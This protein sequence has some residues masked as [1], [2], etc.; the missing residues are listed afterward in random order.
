MSTAVDARPRRPDRRSRTRW[1]LVPELVALG[2]LVVALAFFGDGSGGLRG[3]VARA[4]AVVVE[5]SSPTASHLHDE[6]GPA[7]AQQTFC[8][9]DV[10]GTDPPAAASLAEVRMVYGYY[11][12]ASGTHGLTYA[13]SN[14][15]DGPVV[16]DLKNRVASIAASGAGYDGRVRAMMP[17]QYEARCFGGLQNERVAAAVHDRYDAAL[18]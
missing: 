7:A 2:V 16:V 3:E 6:D 1:W 5:A 13:E 18:T 9:V 15:A 12:C 10:F 8:G 17:D 11:F 4:A 14:R